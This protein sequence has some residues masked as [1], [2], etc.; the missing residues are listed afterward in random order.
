MEAGPYGTWSAGLKTLNQQGTIELSCGEIDSRHASP[1]RINI[2]GK[3]L[4]K[5]RGEGK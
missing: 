5:R 4:S 2:N 1:E 3:E